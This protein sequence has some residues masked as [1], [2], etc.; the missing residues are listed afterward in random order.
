MW[1]IAVVVRHSEAS[2]EAKCHMVDK[3]YVVYTQHAYVLLLPKPCQQAPSSGCVEEESRADQQ[4]P[5]VCSRVMEIE[6]LGFFPLVTRGSRVGFA[7]LRTLKAL[8]F[9]ASGALSL[10]S[11]CVSSWSAVG[12]KMYRGDPLPETF[13][14]KA[15]SR[16]F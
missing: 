13:E 9:V 6:A 11:L 3:G 15:G 10:R 16:V 4:R 5:R 2:A 8:H 7:C 1:F 12:A 14:F